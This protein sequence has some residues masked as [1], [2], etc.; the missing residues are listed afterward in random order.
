MGLLGPGHIQ[1]RLVY[2]SQT[3]K[4]LPWVGKEDKV[5][6]GAP[7][8][9]TPGTKGLRRSDDQESVPERQ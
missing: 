8:V 1:G 9:G 3:S 2:A 4:E 7:S 5:S 6:R